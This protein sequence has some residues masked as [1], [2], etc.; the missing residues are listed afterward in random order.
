MKH[1]IF[2]LLPVLFILGERVHAQAGKAQPIHWPKKPDVNLMDDYLQF[3]K[4][5][6]QKICPV[7]EQKKFNNL[8]KEYR[9][10]GQ[11]LPLNEKQKLD[12]ATIKKNF[13]L[14]TQKRD[15]I[16]NLQKELLK[17]DQSYPGV[18]VGDS[19]QVTIDELTALKRDFVA[20]TNTKAQKKIQNQSQKKLSELH[21]KFRQLTQKVPFLLSFGYPVDHL[22]N[23]DLY[24][25][26][27]YD[28]NR[29]RENDIYFQRKIYED[30]LPRPGTNLTDIYERT[31]FDSIEI[32]LKQNPS[33][34]LPE[35]ILYDLKW[36]LSRTRHILKKGKPYMLAQL[37]QWGRQIEESANFYQEVIVSES[38]H[39]P[40][41]LGSRHAQ[42]SRNLSDFVRTKHAQIYEALA[43]QP[44]W[45]QALYIMDQ[46]LLNEVG[47]ATNENYR[48]RKDI[49]QIVINR[50]QHPIYSKIESKEKLFPY[51]RKINLPKGKKIEDY[52]WLNTLF[53]EG[54]FSFTMF[55]IPAV[56]H[57]ICP[58]FY[59]VA[60][61]TRKKNILLAIDQLRHPDTGFGAL[62][63]F[64]RFSM[65]GKIDISSLWTRYQPIPERPGRMIS[66]KKSFLSQIKA[67]KYQYLYRYTTIEGD[68]F[69]VI[70]HE[71][72]TYAVRNLFE[73]PV[74]YNH[75]DPHLFRYFEERS[76]Q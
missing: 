4:S 3:L 20:T 76:P 5:H 34:F 10:A 49:S 44:E 54:E 13:G 41:Q 11:Y 59:S 52:L 42:A 45:I 18:T 60:R 2:F 31:T 30:G 33:D 19:I 29:T 63:Y 56:E 70:E 12:L 17:K 66:H 38:A 43:K 39:H 55:F 15:W 32:R 57:S 72:K 35:D 53:K 37:E 22:K 65:I 50:S 40:S 25:K 62:R 75:R 71:G 73:N 6:A 1:L 36:L 58:D 14:I 69:D 26:A 23:R 64:S 9:A 74:F 48:D 46:I 7:S 16:A 67:K 24:E 21:K 8:Y 68:D 61:S 28:G 27:K 47:R 51:L